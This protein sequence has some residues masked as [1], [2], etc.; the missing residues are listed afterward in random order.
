MEI[1]DV[2][3]AVWQEQSRRFRPTQRR[4]LGQAGFKFKLTLLSG[5]VQR[6]TLKKK[7][8]LCCARKSFS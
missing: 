2:E 7:I 3:A 5:V 1:S 6:Q 8:L 4:G